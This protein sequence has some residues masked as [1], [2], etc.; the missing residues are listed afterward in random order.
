MFWLGGQQTAQMQQQRFGEGGHDVGV[1]LVQRY[2][3]VGEFV[4]FKRRRK[5]PRVEQAIA[6]FTGLSLQITTPGNVGFDDFSPKSS[7]WL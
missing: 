4:Q 1:A 2:F 7:S 6:T 5:H 3:F